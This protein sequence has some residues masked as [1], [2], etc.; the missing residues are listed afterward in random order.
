[1]L[2]DMCYAQGGSHA[3]TWFTVMQ[4]DIV[5]AM[6]LTGQVVMGQAIMVKSAEVRLTSSC[7]QQSPPTLL[8]LPRR[9]T[10]GPEPN[11]CCAWMSPYMAASELQ[12]EKNLAW[13][14]AQ[15]QSASVAQMSSLATAG[16]GPC[17]LYI[18][19]LHPNITVRPLSHLPP[20][21][22]C[23]LSP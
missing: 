11:K 20:H 2:Q 17:K 23:L 7:T 21:V 16:A 18:K 12:A 1:M 19:N 8:M 10:V 4:E 22:S 3:F 13:E 14:A 15:A 6:G 9:R 5:N